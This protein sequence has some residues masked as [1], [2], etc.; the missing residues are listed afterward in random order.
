MRE[1]SDL[2]NK[3]N[4]ISGIIRPEKCLRTSQDS[5]FARIVMQFN[6]LF[7]VTIIRNNLQN[8][9]YARKQQAQMSE[10]SYS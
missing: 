7:S 3:E 4:N 1:Y 2:T 10:K 6:F 9:F 5:R 8:Y